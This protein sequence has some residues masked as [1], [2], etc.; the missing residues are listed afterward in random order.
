MSKVRT[1][2]KAVIKHV[3]RL[4]IGRANWDVYALREHMDTLKKWGQNL[5]NWKTAQMVMDKTDIITVELSPI[6]AS[7]L[8]SSQVLRRLSNIFAIRVYVTKILRQGK[9]KPE[10][11][12]IM[13]GELSQVKMANRAYDYINE[14]YIRAQKSKTLIPLI[15]KSIDG[16]R[17]PSTIIRSWLYDNVLPA[18]ETFP[19]YRPKHKRIEQSATYL[20]KGYTKYENNLYFHILNTYKFQFKDKENPYY[21]K[22]KT[23]RRPDWKP[24]SDFPNSI[25]YVGDIREKL[26]K[27]NKLLWPG[28]H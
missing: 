13:I 15:T 6:M 24:L 27:Y 17:K 21:T 19:T 28:E 4:T 25:G 12:F 14:I 16:N 7:R 2:R 26:A 11:T 3:K 18:L 5:P 1:H 8:A 20:R 23:D 22:H 10:L 9:N